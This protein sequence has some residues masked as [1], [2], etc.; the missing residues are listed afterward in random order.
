MDLFIFVKNHK[1]NHFQI[2]KKESKI[3]KN[4]KN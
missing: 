4:E 3:V 2:K 1:I